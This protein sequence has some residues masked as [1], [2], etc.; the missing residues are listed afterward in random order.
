MKLLY[1][2]EAVEFVMFDR[3][4]F[5]VFPHPELQGNGPSYGFLSQTASIN[6]LVTHDFDFNK[7]ISEG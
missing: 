5:F 7:C 2:I 1:D 6:F 4:N 3:H